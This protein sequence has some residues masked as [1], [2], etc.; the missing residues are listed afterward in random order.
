MRHRRGLR[1]ICRSGL[2]SRGGEKAP[3]IKQK[4]EFEDMKSKLWKTLTALGLSA[5]LAAALAGCASGQA[6]PDP[7]PAQT[8]ETAAPQP[9]APEYAA[10][11]VWSCPVC[12]NNADELRP[13]RAMRPLDNPPLCSSQTCRGNDVAM[14]PHPPVR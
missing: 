11:N 7:T 2:L 4:E 1:R 3:C 9:E 10:T 13:W 12:G 8:E 6:E 14:V 5:A